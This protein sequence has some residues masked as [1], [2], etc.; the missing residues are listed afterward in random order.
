MKKTN[1]TETSTKAVR[2]LLRGAVGPVWFDMIP[3]GGNGYWNR[4]T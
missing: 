3:G 2:P 1:A 4:I